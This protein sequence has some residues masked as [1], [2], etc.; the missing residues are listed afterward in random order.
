MRNVPGAGAG[1]FQMLANAG[2]NL[3]VFLPV[4][5]YEDQF[6]AVLCPSDMAAAASALG[7]H[8]VRD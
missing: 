4:Q 5:I 2:I 7:D 1:L 6:Y 8:V 3:D